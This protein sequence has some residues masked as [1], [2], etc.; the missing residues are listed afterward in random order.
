M[1]LTF[2]QREAA[3][4]LNSVASVDGPELIGASHALSSYAH[5][6]GTNEIADAI[7]IIRDAKAA[8]DKA[9]RAVER[10]FPTQRENHQNE[11]LH[12]V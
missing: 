1:R 7:D 6:M 10:A 4:R 9:F 2:E 11:G 3:R 5:V 8:F 12:H